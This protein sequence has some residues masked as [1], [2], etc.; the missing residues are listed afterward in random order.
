MNEDAIIKRIVKCYLTHKGE[1]SSR[2][3]VNHIEFTGYG[4]KKP[5]HLKALTRKMKLWSQSGK[6]GSWF[7]VKSEYKNNEQWWSLNE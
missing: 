7:R 2:M 4:L 3:I 6:S 1:A 5:I